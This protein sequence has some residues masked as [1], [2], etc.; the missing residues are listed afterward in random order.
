ML[1]EGRRERI[2]KR[3]ALLNLLESEH[4]RTAD[5]I[6][7]VSPDAPL[8]LPLTLGAPTA[9]LAE[10]V[11]RYSNKKE[12][13]VL[14]AILQL[15]RNVALFNLAANSFNTVFLLKDGTQGRPGVTTLVD[16][17]TEGVVN[18]WSQLDEALKELNPKLVGR[19]AT[20]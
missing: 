5:S 3:D 7:A 10:G 2:A 1:W 12:K 19:D 13:A 20:D 6:G 9:L 17:A 18:A 14:S 4:T 15:Q 11:L 16:K 8:Y